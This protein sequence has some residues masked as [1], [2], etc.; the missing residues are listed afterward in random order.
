MEIYYTFF[1]KISPKE[2]RIFIVFYRTGE[3]SQ[4]DF[5]VFKVEAFEGEP[6]SIRKNTIVINYVARL[7]FE[8]STKQGFIMSL[9]HAPRWKQK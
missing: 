1:S 6:L 4:G 3:T 5:R 7:H 8:R 2:T 9:F